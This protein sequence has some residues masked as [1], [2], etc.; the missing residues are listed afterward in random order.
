[1]VHRCLQNWCYMIRIGIMESQNECSTW[2]N[3]ASFLR[4][5][6][7]KLFS[8]VRLFATPWTIQSKEFSRSEYWSWVARSLIQGIFPTQGLNTGLWH[9]RWI[10]YQLSHQG[11]PRIL[12]WVAYPFSS[13]FSQP[14]NQTG[15]SCTTGRF[16]T[17]WDTR[18]SQEYWSGLP[19]PPPGDLPNPGIKPRYP[20]LQD[21]WEGSFLD[22]FQRQQVLHQ[23]TSFP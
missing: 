8:R 12:G 17:S 16:F 11:S 15:V 9:R 2:A 5:W 20:E 14:R 6:K 23:P 21:P 19:Y 7:W 1:M 22:P 13:G 10:L 3:H 18:E 4:K